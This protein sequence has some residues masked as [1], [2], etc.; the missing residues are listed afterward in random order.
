MNAAFAD[1]DFPKS[2]VVMGLGT[3]GGGVAVTRYLAE[4][5]VRVTVT[6]LR[7]ETELADVLAELDGVPL[8]AVHLGGHPEDLFD[9]AEMLVVNP[10]VRPD[11]IRVAGCRA[12][13]V[14]VTSEMELFLQCNP[15]TVVAVTGSNGKSTTTALIHR[16]LEQQ[17]S[18]PRRVWLG[19]NI[20]RS[21]L[22]VAADINE[23]D[24]VVLELSSFQLHALRQTAF[25]PHVAVITN[26][27][28]N[29]LDWHGSVDHYRASKQVILN[30][31]HRTDIAVVAADD[32]NPDGSSS[33]AG[34][35]WR[36]RGRALRF[37]LSDQEE[38]GAFL[39]SGLLVLRMGGR[40]D[41]VRLELP[42]QLPGDHN[43]Q[44]VAAAV[45][46]AW[47]CGAD[48]AGFQE[49]VSGYQPLPHRLQ[50]V[51]DGRGIRCY[52]D[53]L[54][55]TP[56]SAIAA[57][58]ALP[59]NCVILAGGYD[60]GADLQP[61]ACAIVRY[62]RA[63]VLMGQTAGQ[64]AEHLKT[65]AAGSD[66]P[67]RIAEDFDG[68]VARAVALAPPGGIVLLSPGCASYGWFRD[69]RERGNRF[70][71]LVQQWIQSSPTSPNRD[72]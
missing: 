35:Q 14:I 47:C 6:D 70:T 38:D 34:H 43:R 57:L 16:L 52:T 72:T 32:E 22:P 23:D 33:A 11:D 30:R 55:T 50:L 42:R 62:A 60:K 28:P 29:H 9:Q 44:N 54:A 31:Q 25:A 39:E 68:A 41:A 4:R 3:F 51:A 40:E 56:E 19:G 10:A 65:A 69:F 12:R 48:P 67:V 58:K 59:Q 1:S 66:F 27:S 13:G 7:S 63:A 46:A 26:F 8:Q 37:G 61:F 45:A 36:I 53:S 64:L 24:I 15:A 18:L 49:A 21:L 5:G 71:E 17:I 2:A 20:G